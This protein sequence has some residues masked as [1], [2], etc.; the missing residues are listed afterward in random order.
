ME[1]KLPFSTAML[2]FLLFELNLYGIEILPF[3][4][5]GSATS[6]FELNLYGI[7]ISAV[8]GLAVG[9]LMFE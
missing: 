6:K 9:A 2:S 3:Y 7:E 5:E 4:L 1:L 8:A